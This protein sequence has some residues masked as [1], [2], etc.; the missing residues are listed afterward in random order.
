MNSLE[1]FIALVRDELGLPL[2]VQDADRALHEL[3]GWDS[4][5]LLFLVTVLEN[6]TGRSISV[7]DLFDAPNLEFIYGL[8]TTG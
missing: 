3:P 7:I 6:R 1:E 4:I 2:T 8:A 5:H